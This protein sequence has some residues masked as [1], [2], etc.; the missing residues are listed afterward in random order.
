MGRRPAQGGPAGMT[1]AMGMTTVRV[2]THYDWSGDEAGA[3]THVH[4]AADDLA[5]WLEGVAGAA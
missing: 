3:Q 1:V 2:R 5:S 4:H